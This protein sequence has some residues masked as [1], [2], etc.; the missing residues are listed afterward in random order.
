MADLSYTGKEIF[1]GG[2][3]NPDLQKERDTATF[4][5]TP[6][7]HYLN[8]GLDTYTKKMNIGNNMNNM[9]TVAY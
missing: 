3:T 6:L 5:I 8:G 7:K 2:K 4:D 9:L 1:N